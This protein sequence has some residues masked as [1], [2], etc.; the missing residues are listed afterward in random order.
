M[1]ILYTLSDGKQQSYFESES[2]IQLLWNLLQWDQLNISHHWFRWWLRASQVTR[3]HYLSIWYPSLQPYIYH[4]TSNMLILIKL[5]VVSS[6]MTSGLLPQLSSDIHFRFRSTLERTQSVTSY[7]LESERYGRG[8]TGSKRHWMIAEIFVDII[9]GILY[10][11]HTYGMLIL[12]I[13]LYRAAF[14]ETKTIPIVTI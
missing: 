4:W 14:C 7:L 3:S 13:C 12:D 5:F 8:P 9:L 6:S 10:L 11:N 1:T 2:W